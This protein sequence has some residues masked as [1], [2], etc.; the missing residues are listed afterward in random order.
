MN[1]LF[2]DIPEEKS[3]MDLIYEEIQEIDNK[4]TELVNENNK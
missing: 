3:E 4:F 2:P 1:D